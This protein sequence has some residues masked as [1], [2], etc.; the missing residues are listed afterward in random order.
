MHSQKYLSSDSLQ[1][2]FDAVF[3]LVPAIRKI[4]PQ[5]LMTFVWLAESDR[6]EKVKKGQCQE[7]FSSGLIP[8]SSSP[9]T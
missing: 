1:K 5:I 7:I 4:A 6:N 3:L 9:S 2:R 8:E